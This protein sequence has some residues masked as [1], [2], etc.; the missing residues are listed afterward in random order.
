MTI[1]RWLTVLLVSLVFT[2]PS[3][4]VTDEEIFRAFSLNLTTPGARAI[5]MGGAFIGRADDAT[6]AETNPAGLTILARPEISL[7]YRHRDSRRFETRITNMPITNLDST[8]TPPNIGTNFG[9]ADFRATDELDQVNALGF[10]SYVHPFENWTLGISRHELINAEATVFGEVSASPFHFLEPNSFSGAAEISDVNYG[11]TGATKIGDHVS[12][13]GTLK[14]SD[15]SI[16][17]NIGARQKAQ[18]GFGDH[19]TSIYDTSDVKVGINLGVLVAPVSWVSIGAVYKYDPQ[20][21]L[22]TIVTNVDSAG[23]P[24]QVVTNV[25]FDVPDQLGTGVSVTAADFT[26]NF[27]VIRVFYSQ[28]EDVQ[29]GF[30]LFTH[31]LPFPKEQ[32]VFRIDDGTDIHV[33]AEYLIRAESSVLAFRGGFYRQS[34]N[35]FYFVTAPAAG[36]FLVPIFD[37]EAH[38]PLNHITIGGGVTFGRVQFDAAADFALEDEIR[39]TG[40]LTDRTEVSRRGFELVLSSV[41]RF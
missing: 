33:G 2:V 3:F 8:P 38:D 16:R 5:G 26:V 40:L 19:F 36:D 22:R 21:N 18:P 39:E 1:S 24:Q 27:D 29:A 31:L 11:F 12:L 23:G 41:V 15:F 17:S 7:E 37:T 28:L 25:G 32:V 14:I 34:R 9:L 6:A 35:L 30:S 13:G 10:A 20:F 4:A